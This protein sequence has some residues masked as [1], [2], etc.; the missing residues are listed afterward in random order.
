MHACACNRQGAFCG[1]MVHVCACSLPGAPGGAMVHAY[2]RCPV[3]QWCMHTR[4]PVVQWCMHV[5]VV[6]EAIKW[7]SFQ[8]PH[9]IV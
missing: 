7:D 9:A 3:V 1:A 4:C 6:Y 8:I 5:L 2:T